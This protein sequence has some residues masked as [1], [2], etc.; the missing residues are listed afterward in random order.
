MLLHAR[1]R[2]RAGEYELGISWC[3]RD[4][5]EPFIWHLRETTTREERPAIDFYG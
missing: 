5:R 4:S 3:R 2:R 1:D